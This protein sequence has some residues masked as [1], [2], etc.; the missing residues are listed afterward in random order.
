MEL[1]SGVLNVD[2]TLSQHHQNEGFM[3]ARP[4]STHRSWSVEKL[5]NT[6]LR[7]PT[8]SNIAGI[9]QHFPEPSF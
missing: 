8:D 5:R 2:F 9:P 6:M 7:P 1:E 4:F 3:P